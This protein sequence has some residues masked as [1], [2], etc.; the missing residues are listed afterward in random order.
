M[1]LQAKLNCQKSFGG[2][3]APTL[4]EIPEFTFDLNFEYNLCDPSGASLELS[5]SLELPQMNSLLDDAIKAAI[6]AVDDETVAVPAP[7]R[8]FPP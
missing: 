3:Q 4:G 1:W 7:S 2:T 8:L 6:D 5:A